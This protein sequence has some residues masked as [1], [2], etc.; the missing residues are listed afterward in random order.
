MTVVALLPVI[1]H[2][3]EASF[4]KIRLMPANEFGASKCAAAFVT[5][6]AFEG[7]IG[8][9]PGGGRGVLVVGV[10]AAW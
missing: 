7:V 4:P 1:G 2:D 8:G 3:F 6:V 5:E 9:V 10:G